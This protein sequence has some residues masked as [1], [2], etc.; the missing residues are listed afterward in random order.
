[1]APEYG[2]TTGFWPVDE[3]T[4]AYLRLTGR[5]EEHVALVEAHAR[6]AGLFR[7]AGAQ[8]P[9]YDRV[10]AVRSRRGPAQHRRPEHAAHPAG[11][12]RRR[13]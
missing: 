13:R 9:I 1:M 8:D 3:Q 12:R 5:S 2:A 11:H 10:I 7:A 4:L 6:A